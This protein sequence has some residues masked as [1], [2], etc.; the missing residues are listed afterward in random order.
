MKA[1]PESDKRGLRPVSGEA[2][3]SA[4]TFGKRKAASS[5]NV[6]PQRERRRGDRRKKPRRA[7]STD[8]RSAD[9]ISSY[10]KRA[11]ALRELAEADRNAERKRVL[12]KIVRDYERL[13]DVLEAIDRVPS[14]SDERSWDAIERKLRPHPARNE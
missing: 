3:A 10:R 4:S 8:D 9:P 6:S 14:G 12:L 11:L 2:H 13:A 1:D 7:D 5:E